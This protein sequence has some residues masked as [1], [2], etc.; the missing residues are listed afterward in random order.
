MKLARAIIILA[1][2]SPVTASG[3][4]L[5]GNSLFKRCETG[6][7]RIEAFCFGY[8]A[9]L[10]DALEMTKQICAPESIAIRQGADIVVNYLRAHPE[11]RHH[12]ADSEAFIPLVEAFPCKH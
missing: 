11:G 10:M 5:D 4:F 6:P 3:A 9:G 12:T 8:V 2:L 7:E 1:T